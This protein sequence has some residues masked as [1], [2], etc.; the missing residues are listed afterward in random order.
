[1]AKGAKGLLTGSAGTALLSVGAALLL[2]RHWQRDRAHTA[3]LLESESRFRT[4]VEAA[5]EGIFVA[6]QNGDYLDVNP[7]GWPG[8]RGCAPGCVMSCRPTPS[9]C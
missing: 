3:A 1:M 9:W 8:S 7:A 6:D 5:P 2:H 4:Y